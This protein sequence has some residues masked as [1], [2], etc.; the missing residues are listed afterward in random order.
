MIATLAVRKRI[1]HE[2]NSLHLYCKLRKLG[3]NKKIAKKIASLIENNILYKLMYR[4]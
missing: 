1:E 2:V 3:I 4:K